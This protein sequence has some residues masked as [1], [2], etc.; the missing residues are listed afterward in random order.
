MTEEIRGLNF[1]DDVADNS[2]FAANAAEEHG[3][4]ICFSLDFISLT[5]GQEFYCRTS[6]NTLTLSATCTKTLCVDLSISLIQAFV[7][8]E[9]TLTEPVG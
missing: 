5:R 1:G 3:L 8:K 4:I 7:N 6:A 2:V 9:R